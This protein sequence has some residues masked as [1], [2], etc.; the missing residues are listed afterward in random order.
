MNNNALAADQADTFDRAL[1]EALPDVRYSV[2]GQ[3]Q[4]AGLA[5]GSS[6]TRE[7]PIGSPVGVLYALDGAL[8][9]QTTSNPVESATSPGAFAR[10][11]QAAAN[12]LDERRVVQKPCSDADQSAGT[13]G[14]AARGAS[15]MVCSRDGGEARYCPSVCG[16]KY[17]IAQRNIA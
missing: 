10:F 3:W 12:A 11:G 15:A 7:A 2:L 14:D 8:S 13:I 6:D 4:L 16:A 17:S 5:P 9:V 1:D